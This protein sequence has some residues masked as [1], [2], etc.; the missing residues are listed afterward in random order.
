MTEGG[1]GDCDD[2]HR[3][4]VANAARADAPFLTDFCYVEPGQNAECGF[5]VRSVAGA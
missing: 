3:H 5:A 2:E 4:E 1:N